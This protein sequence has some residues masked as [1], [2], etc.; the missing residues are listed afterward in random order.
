MSNKN[1]ILFKQY[2]KEVSYKRTVQRTSVIPEN[3][4]YQV[5]SQNMVRRLLN[6]CESMGTYM[7]GS[8]WQVVDGYAQKLVN[9]GYTRKKTRKAS[10]TQFI[11][12]SNDKLI[13]I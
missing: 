12:N 11:S 7:S 5:L 10:N 9:S 3:T 6:T 4:K 8:R 2:E 13:S 1:E